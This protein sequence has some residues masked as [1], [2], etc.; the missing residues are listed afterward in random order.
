[1]SF[2]VI[3]NYTDVINKGLMFFIARFVHNF[4]IFIQAKM[5]T[6]A[7]WRRTYA[8]PFIMLCDY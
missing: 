3:T 5:V 2:T 7:R 6:E 1:M 4:N 8:N